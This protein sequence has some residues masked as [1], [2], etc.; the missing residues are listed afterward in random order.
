MKEKDLQKAILDFL[1]CNGVLAWRNNTGSF[2]GE[3]KGKKRFVRFS[4]PG[5]ADIFALLKKGPFLAIEVKASGKRPTPIQLAWGK[6][7]REQG[8]LWLWF[9]NWKEFEA[10]IGFLL[11]LGK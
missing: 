1:N 3:Y 5:A 6:M 11:R 2:A 8:H 10:E 9:D 7:I 4:T